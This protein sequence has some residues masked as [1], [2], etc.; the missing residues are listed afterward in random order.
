VEM[1]PKKLGNVSIP[2]VNDVPLDAAVVAFSL[3]VAAITAVLCGLP[4]AIT[5]TAHDVEQTL[6]EGATGE[7]RRA[8]RLRRFLVSA[9]LALAT[10]IAV[11][12]GLLLRSSWKL[13]DTDLGFVGE[14]TLSARLMLSEKRYPEFKQ[15]QLV[16]DVLER[17]RAR[18]EIESAGAISTLPL[19][20][21]WAGGSVILEKGAEPVDDLSFAV[22]ENG[23]F[24][25]MGIPLVSGRWFSPADTMSTPKVTLVD[26]RF[27]RKYLGGADPIGRQLNFG[28]DAEPEML[29]V[30]G[31]VGEVLEN[32]PTGEIRPMM[33][34]PW[35]Q[36][37][38]PLIALV[39]RPRAG[40]AVSLAGVMR[41]AVWDVDGDQPISYVM[42]IDEMRS[43]ATA[44]SR[45]ISALFLFFA[46]TAL[47]LGAL[48]VYGLTAHAVA[49]RTREIGL[50]MALGARRIDVAGWVVRQAL[51]LVLV[52]LAVGVGL[53]LALSRVLASQLFG[54]ATYDA[55]TLGSVALALALAAA[56][57]TWVPAR[58]ASRV[59]PAVALRAE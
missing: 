12:A 2:V 16:A 35:S 15:S 59:D 38:W 9:E 42:T 30:V 45:V 33:Y 32:G 41:N 40:A 5:A 51:P 47:L 43:D 19:S 56:L 14:R 54:V 7:S 53:S 20:G 13:S 34:V 3:L 10:V 29:T 48:G 52:G 39:A 27:I 11:G 28:S 37:P 46:A 36:R 25:T 1:F 44:V 8:L 50:R 55:L 18:P 21:W 57:A 17:L 58:R 4:A 31:V 23:Y 26:T 24:A 49:R 22:A 6:R